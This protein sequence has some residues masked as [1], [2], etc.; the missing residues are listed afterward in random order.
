MMKNFMAYSITAALGSVAVSTMAIHYT[1]GAPLI[2]P[3]GS[4]FVGLLSYMAAL[5]K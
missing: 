3:I 2:I 4:C 5:G 1:E